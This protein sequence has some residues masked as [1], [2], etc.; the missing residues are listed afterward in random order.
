MVNQKKRS[1]LARLDRWRKAQL[2]NQT[3]SVKDIVF[4]SGNNHWIRKIK[5]GFEVYKIGITHSTRCSQIGHVGKVGLEKAKAEIKRRESTDQCMKRIKAPKSK[6][7][8][9]RLRKWTV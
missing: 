5:G 4:E 3:C 7:K 8:K 6:K 2:K 1:Q 9:V